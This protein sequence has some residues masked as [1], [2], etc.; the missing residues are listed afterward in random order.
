MSKRGPDGKF[1][2]NDYETVQWSSQM[3]PDWVKEEA[4]RIKARMREGWVRALERIGL[5]VEKM[6]RGAVVRGSNHRRR[7]HG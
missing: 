5:D 2:R 6:R 3:S 4:D 7:D 1:V